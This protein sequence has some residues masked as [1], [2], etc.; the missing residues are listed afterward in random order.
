MKQG[1][2]CGAAALVAAC[3]WLGASAGVLAQGVTVSESGQAIYSLPIAV[4]PGVGGMEPKLSLVY[5]SGGIN[6]PVGVGW[7]VQGISQITRCARTERVNGK[8]AVRAVRLEAGDALCLDGQRLIKVDAGAGNYQGTASAD[9]SQVALGGVATEFRTEVDSY[10]RIRASGAVDA[11]QP[12]YG[13]ATFVVQSKAGLTSEY[14]RLGTANDALVRSHRWVAAGAYQDQHATAWLLKRVTDSVGNTLEFSYDNTVRTWGTKGPNDAVAPGSEWNL[15]GVKYGCNTRMA[16]NQWHT[17]TLVYGDRGDKAEAYHQG[18]KVVNTQ[19]LNRV[20]VHV[21]ATAGNPGQLVR[22]YRLAHEAST[23]TARSVLKAI[24]ECADAA[25]ANCLPPH[26]FVYTGAIGNYTSSAAFNLAGTALSSWDERH[27]VITGDYDG[28]GK[29]DILRTDYWAGQVLPEGT[30]FPNALWLASA[31]TPGAFVQAPRFSSFSDSPAAP[32]NSSNTLAV[33]RLAWKVNSAA[34]DDERVETFAA[35]INGDG[36]ADL[37]RLCKSLNTTWCPKKV[38]MWVSMTSSTLADE[39]DFG[40]FREIDIPAAGPTEY[41]GAGASLGKAVDGPLFTRQGSSRAICYT[42]RDE[43]GTV[44]NYYRDYSS[45]EDALWQDVDGD[46]RVD[47]VSFQYATESTPFYCAPSG[48]PTPKLMHYYAGRGDGTFVQK[49]IPVTL[50]ATHRNVGEKTK[51]GLSY[52][53]VM[54]ING[55]GRPD[56]LFRRSRWVQDADGLFQLQNTPVDPS[57]QHA[58]YRMLPVDVNGDGRTDIVTLDPAA[59]M[60]DPNG[61]GRTVS[62]NPYAA[63]LFVN[64]GNGSFVR[65]DRPISHINQLGERCAPTSLGSCLLLTEGRMSYGS[66]VN[67]STP[68][69]LNGD[70]LG[71]FLTWIGSALVD[72]PTPEAG[73]MHLL[74]GRNVPDSGG[75]GATVPGISTEAA[76]HGLPADLVTAGNTFAGGDFLGLGSAGFLK[77]GNNGGNSLWY[78]AGP[79]PDML[80]TAH[81]PTGQYTLVT[82]ASTAAAKTGVAVSNEE[83]TSSVY[84]PTRPALALPA[85]TGPLGPG[86]VPQGTWPIHH[87]H[88]A[89]WVVGRTSQDAVGSNVTTAFMY[90]GMK[91]DLTGGGSL[92]F[93]AVSKF[94]PY[95][96]GGMLVTTTEYLQTPLQ[97]QYLGMPMCTYTRYNPTW[98]PNNVQVPVNQLIDPPTRPGTQPLAMQA[99]GDITAASL[100]SRSDRSAHSLCTDSGS[101]SNPSS[102]TTRLIDMTTY[103]Y[104]DVQAQAVAGTL[105]QPAEVASPVKRPYQQS[106]T[107]RSWDINQ[108][109]KPISKVE[110]RNTGMTA[111]GDVLASTATTTGYNLPGATPGSLSSQSWSKTTQH[112]YGLGENFISGS[113]WL[114][115]RL[116][117]SSVTATAPTT[118]PPQPDSAALSAQQRATQDPALQGTPLRSEQLMVI[119]QLLLED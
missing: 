26:T 75:T 11:A 68:V 102:G 30:G 100:S 49:Q 35:D 43:D 105:D 29:T 5:N 31:T 28:N 115:G 99:A 86:Q 87:A 90:R 2:G 66:G 65:D 58:D 55:D 119:L 21:G 74:L 107:Q 93:E 56:I 72:D 116:K 34:T 1:G 98:E 12:A 6:G 88:P 89:T 9:Q 81:G 118:S 85:G 38:R 94:F 61:S 112:T 24:T 101:E 113:K 23:R 80:Q 51:S 32:A 77:M 108:P 17:V 110:T 76:T 53:E 3:A 95:A 57:P 106:S 4:P 84:Q 41:D 111:Y 47:L 33:T 70:S 97:P 20:D 83:V 27:S 7:A 15:V 44:I 39:A 91:T 62:A 96:N 42:W 10:S 114:L 54:D 71:D 78:R 63:R 25:G 92:G 48:R 16:C 13:P 45:V 37:I 82:Y 52:M 109:D 60:V 22:S 59:T 18:G 69:D 73:G 8:P 14:G 36:R 46:G 117:T 104:G 67:G 64:Q 40:V 103:T 50:A 79:P 19:L